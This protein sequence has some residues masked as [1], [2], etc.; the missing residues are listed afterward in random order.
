M[1]GHIK[2]YFKTYPLLETSKVKQAN[3]PTFILCGRGHLHV[4]QTLDKKSK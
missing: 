2:K 3:T 4:V 1:G